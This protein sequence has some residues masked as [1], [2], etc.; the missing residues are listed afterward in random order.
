MQRLLGT[1]KNRPLPA[2]KNL[3]AYVN[4]F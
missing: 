4:P 1:L 3:L 2:W